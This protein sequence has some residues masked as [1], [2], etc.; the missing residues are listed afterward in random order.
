MRV[1]MLGCGTSSGVPRIGG[2]W[3]ACD[4]NE[5][6]NRRRRVSVWVE[7]GE[8]S[9]VIDTAPDFREQALDAGIERV[10]GVLFTHDHADH[11]HG[12]DDLRMLS[13]VQRAR[14]PVYSDQSTLDTLKRRFEYIFEGKGGYPAICMQNTI[15]AGKPFMVGDAEVFAFDQQHGSVTTLG[16]RFGDFAYSTDLNALDEKA[17]ASLEGVKVW[18]V[19]ALRYEAHP[20]HTHLAQTLEWIARVAP[21]RA[22]L[23]HMT[24]DM[25]YATLKAELPDGVEP[26]YD[27]MIIEV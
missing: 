5:P 14:I 11:T 13:Y 3:G 2:E 7:T 9:L 26:G 20:T 23:T 21:Q 12:I 22:I 4:P 8:T 27:G 25:D 19:D 10:D 17:F 18:I 24:W 16:F 1:T 6:K 15:A